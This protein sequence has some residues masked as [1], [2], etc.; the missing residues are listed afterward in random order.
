MSPFFALHLQTARRRRHMSPF[1]A[2]H[3]CFSFSGENLPED[4]R[5]LEQCFYRHY[6][7]KAK[8]QSTRVHWSLGLEAETRSGFCIMMCVFEERDHMLMTNKQCS[9]VMASLFYLSIKYELCERNMRS[10]IDVPSLQHQT[11]DSSTH[12]TAVAV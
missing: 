8:C 2:L 5:Q 1:F 6:K 12:R 7:A 10:I 9:L 4:V 3:L 11:H